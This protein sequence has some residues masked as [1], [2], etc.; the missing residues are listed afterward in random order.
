MRT[1]LHRQGAIKGIVKLSPGDETSTDAIERY[2]VHK[3]W[4]RHVG[5]MSAEGALSVP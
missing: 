5:G 3:D 1:S 2:A 4:L